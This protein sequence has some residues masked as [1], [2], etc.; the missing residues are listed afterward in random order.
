[1]AKITFIGAGSTVFA[2]N[3]LGDILGLPELA[4]SE[5]ALFDIDEARLRTSEIVAGKTAAA[6]GA[7]AEDHGHHRPPAGARRRRLR[8][9]HDP[10]RRLPA[11]DGDRLRGPE[12]VRPAPDDRRHARHR[13]H[14]ARPAHHARA[15]RHVRRHGT[16]LP[17]T[18]RFLKYVNP[19]AINCWAI[20]RADHDPHRRP[21]PQ[22]P[23]HRRT[24][25]PATSAC[26]PRTIRYLC[27]GINHMAFYLRF[28]R[29][30]TTASR[31]STRRS[32]SSRRVATSRGGA[33]PTGRTVVSPACPTPSATRCSGASA[34]SSP[35][36]ASTSP[37]TCRGSSSA[38]GP[39]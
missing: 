29:R 20:N 30:T 9:Q 6:V 21:L 31:T 3:L 5:I 7:H 36:P 8:D 24:S 38:T 27:A 15:A 17:A 18:R 28:E 34:T 23:A 16:G 14:H 19:M 22:R 10:G 4:D 2:K 35:S 12:A 1:M 26:R 33:A 37:S 13:R 11:L 25:S 32:P 39:T